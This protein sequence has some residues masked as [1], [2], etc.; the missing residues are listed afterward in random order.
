MF[1]Q[2]AGGGLALARRRLPYTAWRRCRCDATGTEAAVRRVFAIL[3]AAV[4]GAPRAECVTTLPLHGTETVPACDSRTPDCHPA[5]AK[6]YAYL[7]ALAEDP[8]IVT[9]ALQSSPWRMYGPD[10]RI[11]TV[12]EAAA[13]IR[14]LLTERA[15]KVQFIGSWTGVAPSERHRSLAVRV[16]RALDGFPVEGFDGFLWIAPDGK[17]R[18][19]QQAF[20]GR[21]GG[22]PYGVRDGEEVMVALVAGWHISVESHWVEQGNADGVLHA[23][24]GWDVFGLCPD[25]ALASFE[26]AAGLGSAIGAYNAA[27]MRLEKGGAS[28]RKAA[29]ALLERAAGL[30][31]DKARKKLETLA[32]R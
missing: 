23:A 16:S 9:I 26:K 30:G 29:H 28:N 32:P 13:A 15:K 10:M 11:L 14:P 18:T 3:L 6:L 25:S 22:G 20:T 19:T 4:A 1:A 2:T 17:L 21:A 7:N 5:A 12:D 31:D 8:A 27:L 24:A